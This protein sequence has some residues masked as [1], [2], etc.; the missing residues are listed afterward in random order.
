MVVA[1]VVLVAQTHFKV[2]ALLV[3]LVI[4]L[5]ELLELLEFLEVVVVLDILVHQVLVVQA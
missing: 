2:Q 1:L 4:L 3:L 5:R